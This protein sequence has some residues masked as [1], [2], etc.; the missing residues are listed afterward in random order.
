M[1]YGVP[2]GELLYKKLI[3]PGPVLSWVWQSV[4]QKCL[5][6]VGTPPCV[7]QENQADPVLM[8]GPRDVHLLCH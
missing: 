8:F 1:D 6:K 7:P 2:S 5:S 3:L 4:Q